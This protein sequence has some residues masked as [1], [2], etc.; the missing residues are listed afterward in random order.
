[1]GG[2]ALE[3]LGPRGCARVHISPGITYWGLNI[4]LPY[5]RNETPSFCSFI[6]TQHRAFNLSYFHGHTPFLYD[7]WTRDLQC[8]LFL[9]FLMRKVADGMNGLSGLLKFLWCH[10]RDEGLRVRH[11]LLGSPADGFWQRDKTRTPKSPS[12]VLTLAQ[13]KPLKKKL[14]W[15]VANARLSR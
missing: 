1:M 2:E 5:L 9:F 13:N 7:A 11:L 15:F 10:R 8:F 4:C 12:Q 6:V 3:K 14:V